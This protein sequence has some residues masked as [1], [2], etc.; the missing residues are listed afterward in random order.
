MNPDI[1]PWLTSNDCG[2]LFVYV[3]IHG[4]LHQPSL[5]SRVSSHAILWLRVNT[6]ENCTWVAITNKLSS[7]VMT[8][9]PPTQARTTKNC[10]AAYSF[11][12]G[13]HL[14]EG[15]N[16]SDVSPQS[17]QE[18]MRDPEGREIQASTSLDDWMTCGLWLLAPNSH[19]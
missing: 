9:D 1:E 4:P 2:T 10:L 12:K 6:Q 18:W 7:A 3:A 8:V 5:R 11:E 15:I 14:E 13:L 16:V 17:F 19:Y